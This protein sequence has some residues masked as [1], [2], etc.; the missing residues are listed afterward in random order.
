MTSPRTIDLTPTFAEAARLLAVVFENGTDAGK[1]HAR[2]ELARWAD[3]LDRTKAE[4]SAP[5]T[6]WD[7]ISHKRKGEAY[8]VTLRTEAEA[9]AYAAQMAVAGYTSEILPHQTARNVRAALEETADFFGD[10]SIAIA[11]PA[12]SA[13]RPTEAGA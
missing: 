3:M 7:V 10:V 12:N 9:T 11:A 2:A 5:V 6:V 4:Q 13:D 1:A 8:G